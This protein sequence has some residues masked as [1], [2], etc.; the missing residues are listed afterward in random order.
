M[1]SIFIYFF[2]FPDV[3]LLNT[4]YYKDPI[5]YILIFRIDQWTLIVLLTATVIH[6]LYS[7]LYFTLKRK[8]ILQCNNG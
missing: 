5:G 2:L 4:E 3:K 8:N 7:E 6:E 1:Q